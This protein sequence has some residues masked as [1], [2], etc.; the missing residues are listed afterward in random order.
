MGSAL[1]VLEAPVTTRVSGASNLWA[2]CPVVSRSVVS[3]AAAQNE[4]DGDGCDHNDR[5]DADPQPDR[6]AALAAVHLVSGSCREEAPVAGLVADHTAVFG[7]R[8]EAGEAVGAVGLKLLGVPE[9]DLRSVIVVLL[10][11]LVDEF[12]ALAL[13]QFCVLLLVQFVERLVAVAVLR[14]RTVALRVRTRSARVDRQ[15]VF[16]VGG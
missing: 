4:R 3:V 7:L 12:L 15:L 6:A 11:C 16:R 5:T 13:V 10:Q 8:G 9:G 2:R 1:K 14:G